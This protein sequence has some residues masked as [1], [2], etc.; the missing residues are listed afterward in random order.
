MKITEDITTA[1]DI[2]IVALDEDIEIDASLTC[3]SGNIFIVGKNL[4]LTK[5]AVMKAKGRM[6]DLRAKYNMNVSKETRSKE[7]EAEYMKCTIYQGKM[8][9]ADLNPEWAENGFISQNIKNILNIQKTVENS[10]KD[11]IKKYNLPNTSQHCL[12]RGLRNASADNETE[13]LKFFIKHV[14]NPDAQDTNPYSQKTALHWAAIKGNSECYNLL[15]QAGAPRILI[16][17]EV[18]E[19]N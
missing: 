18:L 11:L 19:Y 4:T 7:F 17:E 12:E 15:I 5:N 2:I 3:T 13:D 8:D 14:N 6:I 16:M 10:I 9:N 1:N